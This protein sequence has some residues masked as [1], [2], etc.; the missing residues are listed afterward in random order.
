MKQP[1]SRTSSANRSE[2]TAKRIVSLKKSKLK[3]DKLRP[4]DRKEHLDL[5]SFRD[6]QNNL[7]EF[8]HFQ[9]DHLLLTSQFK[10]H[11]SS[12]RLRSSWAYSTSKPNQQPIPSPPPA[13]INNPTLYSPAKRISRSRYS[14]DS[15]IS[16]QKQQ[17]K[18]SSRSLPRKFDSMSC[19]NEVSRLVIFFFHLL[20]FSCCPFEHRTFSA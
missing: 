7:P 12:D 15:V 17:A 4:L 13:T 20:F 5:L 10:T 14:Y 6:L 2:K 11:P 19:F 3:S 8:R 9:S 1:E 18:Y 16:H